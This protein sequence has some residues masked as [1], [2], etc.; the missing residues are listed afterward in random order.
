MRKEEFFELRDG[1]AVVLA[2]VLDEAGDGLKQRVVEAG[3][4]RV[5]RHS[6]QD[7]DSV[8]QHNGDERR[9]ITFD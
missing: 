9:D 4:A 2:D 1:G 6:G 8:L 7:G 5:L 3:V